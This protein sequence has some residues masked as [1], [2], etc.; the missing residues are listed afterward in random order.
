ML[1]YKKA[2]KRANRQMYFMALSGDEKLSRLV[3]D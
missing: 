2:Q 1:V 3:I